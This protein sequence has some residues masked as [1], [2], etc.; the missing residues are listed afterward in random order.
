[1]TQQVMQTDASGQANLKMV[2]T[3]SLISI[4]CP[5]LFFIG[6][7]F[8]GIILAIIALVLGDKVQHIYLVENPDPSTWDDSPALLKAMVY[9]TIG[10][11]LNALIVAFFINFIVIMI[12][13]N[14]KL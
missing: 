12:M 4:A 8:I 7:P 9:A 1:M 3:L 14:M 13:T 11:A 10:F 6:A 5:L 2:K